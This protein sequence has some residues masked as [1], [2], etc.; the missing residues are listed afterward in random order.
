MTKRQ[1]KFIRTKGEIKSLRNVLKRFRAGQHLSELDLYTL[2]INGLDMVFDIKFYDQDMSSFISNKITVVAT[3]RIS[4]IPGMAYS[5]IAIKLLGLTGYR[6][7]SMRIPSEMIED[8][9]G[10][11]IL[12]RNRFS[13]L[14]N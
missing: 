11:N 2:R 3:N 13:E 4:R 10:L 12:I 7:K 8:K 6:F 14:I 5:F 1:Y 9:E